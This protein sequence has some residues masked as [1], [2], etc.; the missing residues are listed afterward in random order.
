MEQ[1]GGIAGIVGGLKPKLDD[2]VA[3]GADVPGDA[4]VEDIRRLFQAIRPVFILSSVFVL[5]C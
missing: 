2:T 3:Y 1:C 5:S 4:P